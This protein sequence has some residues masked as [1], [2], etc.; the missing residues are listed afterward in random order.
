[1]M[2]LESMNRIRAENTKQN[3]GTSVGMNSE[4]L[5]MICTRFLF[6][7]GKVCLTVRH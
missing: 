2:D 6:V 7:N 5:R 3:Q 1:M 4:E